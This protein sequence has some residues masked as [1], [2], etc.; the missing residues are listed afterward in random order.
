MRRTLWPPRTGFLHASNNVHVCDV[1]QFVAW[2]CG[3]TAGVQSRIICTGEDTQDMLFKC[4]Q[5]AH[6][7]VIFLMNTDA[8]GDALCCAVWCLG[9]GWVYRAAGTEHCRTSV[10]VWTWQHREINLSQKPLLYFSL[11]GSALSGPFWC[12]LSRSI[13]MDQMYRSVT[14]CKY[15]T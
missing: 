15:C 2:I 8:V 9:H 7:Y 14:R 12:S 13:E 6:L 11:A 3:I 10:S 1:L 5:C 4:K